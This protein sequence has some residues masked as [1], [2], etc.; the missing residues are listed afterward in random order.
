MRF[1]LILWHWT[2]TQT[3]YSVMGFLSTSNSGDSRHNTSH[4]KS[5]T[6]CSLLL[7]VG[8]QQ[9]ASFMKSRVL[10]RSNAAQTAMV[11]VCVYQVPQQL[12]M[13]GVESNIDSQVASNSLSLFWDMECCS[14][15]KL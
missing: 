2:N 15:Q 13:T 14:L 4:K 12:S 5:Q 8:L 9:N 1:D 11:C 10:A 7:H 3:I 6:S